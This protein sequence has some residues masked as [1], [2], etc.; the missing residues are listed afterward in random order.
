[1]DATWRPSATIGPVTRVSTLN[2]AIEQPLIQHLEYEEVVHRH[3]HDKAEDH[4]VNQMLYEE[5][6]QELLS[7]N[8]EEY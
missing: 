2:R 1:M 4:H 3:E 5:T 8:P 6:N 7:E